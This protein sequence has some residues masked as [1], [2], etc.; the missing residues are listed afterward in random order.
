MANNNVPFFAINDV[1][2]LANSDV[3]FLAN[4]DVHLSLGKGFPFSN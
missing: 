2:Q 4:K 1:Q 3:P